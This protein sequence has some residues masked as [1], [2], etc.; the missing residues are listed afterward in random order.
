MM[1]NTNYKKSRPYCFRQ[2]VISRYPYIS[3]CKKHLTPGWGH[4]L[5]KWY[6]LNKL[7]RGLLVDASYQISRLKALWF[8][9]RRFF[10]NLPISAYVKHVTLWAVPFLAPGL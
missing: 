5:S 8:Q 3:L 9:T 4:F 6:N 7:G 10:Y 1:L 2:E